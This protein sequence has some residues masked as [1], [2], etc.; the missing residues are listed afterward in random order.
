MRHMKTLLQFDLARHDPEV[1]Q[2]LA[3]LWGG[4]GKQHIIQRL[5]LT[6]WPII[7]ARLAQYY[8]LRQEC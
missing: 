3:K 7:I 2:L 5:I 4:K 8:S 1:C 6:V